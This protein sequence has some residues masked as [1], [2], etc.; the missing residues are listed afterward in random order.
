MKISDYLRMLECAVLITG[1]DWMLFDHIVQSIETRR[2]L[3]VTSRSVR[4]FK[5]KLRLI[6]RNIGEMFQVSWSAPLEIMEALI[7]YDHVTEK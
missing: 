7:T 2:K 6:N 5:G 1:I 4:N 3:H